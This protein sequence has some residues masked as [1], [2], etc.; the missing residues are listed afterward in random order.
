MS[1]QLPTKFAPSERA[2]AETIARQSSLFSV[3]ESL[4]PL[5]HA[6]PDMLVVL[7][8]QRQIV[9]ANK[10]FLEAYGQ[11][12]LQTVIG[13]RPG[14]VFHCIHAKE[15][16]AGC[17]TTE[18]CVTCGAVRA[19]LK[20]QSGKADVQECRISV[21]ENAV[22][23]A[24]DLRVWAT[25]FE[26]HGEQFVAFA[27]VDISDEKR[28][29]VLERIFF[30][31]IIN[32]AGAIQGLA[33]LINTMNDP[34]EIAEFGFGTMLSQV[35]VQLL[36]EIQAQRQLLAA[37]NGELEVQPESV[38]TAVLLEKLLDLYRHH[39]VCE[40]R[41]LLLALSLEDVVICSDHALLGRVI[42]NM[43][44]NALEACAE[45]DT[46]TVGCERVYEYVRFWVHNPTFMPRRV[47]LQVFNRSFSTKGT[48]R[49]LG[50]YSMKLLSEN[51]LQGRVSFESH[52]V[53]GT[54]FYGMY[55]IRWVDAAEG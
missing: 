25:P 44:K 51:Y 20:A 54:T 23:S 48:G 3:I 34:N 7:N 26:F 55:P 11:G 31:D 8:K 39:P 22:I 47:Q 13:L 21:M 27:F 29:Q 9:Y 5:I 15:E 38:S 42:G 35:S 49:G 53:Y 12:D 6:V 36:D 28:R 4:P 52:E 14:E 16:Q 18:F 41:Q 45:G 19:I 30:H 17:G 10:K 50:T 40:G 43:I 2:S 37:E 24:L 33:E 46:V 1:T 32:T